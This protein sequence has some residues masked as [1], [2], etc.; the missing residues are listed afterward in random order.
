MPKIFGRNIPPVVLALTTAVAGYLVYT[1]L[2]PA[3]EP[4]TS[5][6]KPA[7]TAKKGVGETD[8]LLSDY[9]FKTDPLPNGVT[10]KD[11]FKPLVVKGGIGQNGIPSIDNYTYSGMA[12][13]DGHAE[14]LLE[15]GQTGQ[16]DFVTMGQK[17]HD[18]W[19]VIKI[20]PEDIQ[21][22]NDGG[23]IMTLE[24]GAAAQKAANNAASPANGPANPMMVGPIGGQDLTIQP[25][26]NNPGG[27]PG[28]NRRNRRGRG[29][30]GGGGGGGG[31]SGGFG[32]GG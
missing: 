20:S 30:R 9:I 11:A 21:L 13:V 22:K 24:A 19:L 32:G 27:G 16:G 6:K 1:T 2:F 5:S 26:P 25:D 17:W 4:V 18:T 10:L 31:N 15:N 3:D 23:D 7:A 8:Y 28:N 12:S 29:G 14:G